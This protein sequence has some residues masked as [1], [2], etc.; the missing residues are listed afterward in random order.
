M[1]FLL[2][3]NDTME[4]MR[5]E[6]ARVCGNGAARALACGETEPAYINNGMPLRNTALLLFLY[7][8]SKLGYNMSYGT[9]IFDSDR[10]MGRLRSVRSAFGKLNNLF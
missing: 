9:Q 1:D 4:L 3:D 10:S 7:F 6:F 5:Q 8:I 2:P